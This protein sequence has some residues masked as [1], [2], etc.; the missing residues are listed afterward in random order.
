MDG[1]NVYVATPSKPFDQGKAVIFLTNVFG[2]AL[3]QNRVRIG[4][5]RDL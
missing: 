3:V 5:K 1:D 4:L 2:L